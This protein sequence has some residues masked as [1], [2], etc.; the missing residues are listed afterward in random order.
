MIYVNPLYIQLFE[1][2]GYKRI[3]F[4][5]LNKRQLSCEAVIYS[6]EI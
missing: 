5:A 1:Q 4:I 3:N 2:F 6:N